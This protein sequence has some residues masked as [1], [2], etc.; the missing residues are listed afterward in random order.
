[1]LNYRLFSFLLLLPAS[2]LS[3]A[4][5]PGAVLAG[6]DPKNVMACPEDAQL[7]PPFVRDSAL[8][9]AVAQTLRCSVPG[10]ADVTWTVCLPL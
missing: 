3:A 2:G 8:G 9:P 7:C 6:A 10:R 4:A 5:A 1:M